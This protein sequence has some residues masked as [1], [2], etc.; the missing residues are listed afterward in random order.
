MIPPSGATASCA[1][2]EEAARVA[3]I[4]AINSFLMS[5]SFVFRLRADPDLLKLYQYF[6]LI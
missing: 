2:A 4:M 1:W 5:H 3:S 6:F